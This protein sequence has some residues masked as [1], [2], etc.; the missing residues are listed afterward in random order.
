MFCGKNVPLSTIFFVSVQAK[1]QRAWRVAVLCQGLFSSAKVFI[2]SEP[3]KGKTL[4]LRAI[5]QY[6]DISFCGGGYAA[7]AAGLQAVKQGIKECLF[8]HNVY[9]GI[10]VV[11]HCLYLAKVLIGECLY[12]GS[13]GSVGNGREGQVH[14]F[15]TYRCRLFL[16]H[17]PGAQW[18]VR[19]VK[20]HLALFFFTGM[21]G[22]G[23]GK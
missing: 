2:F 4:F 23:A 11:A 7:V 5:G 20:Q 14:N 9:C 12:V 13:V 19:Q 16:F 17:V 6:F 3:C 22:V 15:T 10:F 18:V 1:S 8:A 21:V